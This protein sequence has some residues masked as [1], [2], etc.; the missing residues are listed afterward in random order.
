M[1]IVFKLQLI[2]TDPEIDGSHAAESSDFHKKFVQY[3]RKG[4]GS[5]QSASTSKGKSDIPLSSELKKFLKD[6][7]IK[8]LKSEMGINKSESEQSPLPPMYSKRRANTIENY[9]QNKRAKIMTQCQYDQLPSSSKLTNECERENKV[10]KNKIAFLK[11]RMRQTRLQKQKRRSALPCGWTN[12][13]KL[14]P[15]ESPACQPTCDPV[16]LAVHSVP[17]VPGPSNSSYGGMKKGF[18]L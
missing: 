9:R 4:T 17:A 15:T 14:M 5:N 11:A 10:M 12:S 16:Q 13:S 6:M 8:K 1:V 3:L 18:L 2:A 7:V